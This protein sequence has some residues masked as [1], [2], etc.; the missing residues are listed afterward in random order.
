MVG[1][2]CAPAA[3]NDAA[4][5]LEKR[6]SFLH[7]KYQYYLTFYYRTALK[8]AWI[9]MVTTKNYITPVR[10]SIARAL[11]SSPQQPCP[12]ANDRQH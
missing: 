10:R 5:P 1:V 9:N 6:V 11:F 2:F 3:P 12:Y 7:N 4:A 8:P